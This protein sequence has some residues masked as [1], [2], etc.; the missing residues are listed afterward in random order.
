MLF[1]VYIQACK[2]LFWARDWYR[3]GRLA[4]KARGYSLMSHAMELQC[5]VS[6]PLKATV[7]MTRS[8]SLD[9]IQTGLECPV[10]H[11]DHPTN[12]YNEGYSKDRERSEAGAY[13][14][15]SS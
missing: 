8:L 3:A 4:P 12:R 6:F 15:L 9:Q 14:A 13:D 11:N 5:C 7:I 2:Q 1:I 10:K